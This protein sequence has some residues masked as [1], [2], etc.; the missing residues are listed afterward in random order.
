MGCDIYVDRGRGSIFPVAAIG[1]FVAQRGAAP[2]PL[3]CDADGCPLSREQL[4]SSVQSYTRQVILAPILA[5]A[6]ALA[7]PQ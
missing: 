2:G 6:F 5:T 4:S 1:N 7:Q 3:F